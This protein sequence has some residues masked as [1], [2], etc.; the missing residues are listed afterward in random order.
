MRIKGL[1]AAFAAAV[2][3]V[4]LVPAPASAESGFNVLF[5]NRHSTKC[6]EI[7]YGHMGDFVQ[8]TQFTCSGAPM[9]KWHYNT[10]TGIIQ[11]ADTSKCLEVFYS[12]TANFAAVGQYECHG[13]ANQRWW[14]NRR[15]GIIQN[16]HS[17]KCLEVQWSYT[18]DFA[19]V[20]QYDCHYGN[21]QRWSW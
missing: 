3:A 15:T 8:A 16:Q 11:R 20:G 12:S 7:P 6:L 18:H 1:L 4:V 10:Q 13:G 2:T 19:P 14:F 5:M 9:Q 21:N 17:Y